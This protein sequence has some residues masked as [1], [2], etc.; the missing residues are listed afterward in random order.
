MG[1]RARGGVWIEIRVERGQGQERLLVEEGEEHM[2]VP[3][4]NSESDAEWTTAISG[5]L[6]L[7]RVGCGS[8]S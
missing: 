6:L 4:R 8:S 7:S 1:K 3:E 5:V 2:L